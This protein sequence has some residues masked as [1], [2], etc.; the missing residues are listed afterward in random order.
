M[1]FLGTHQVAKGHEEISTNQTGHR[2]GTPRE[3]PITSSLVAAM[4][5]KELRLYCQIPT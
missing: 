4:S 5:V 2:R 3:T 1:S